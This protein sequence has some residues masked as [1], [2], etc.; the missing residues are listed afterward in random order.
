ME[1]LRGQPEGKNLGG[2]SARHRVE[3]GRASGSASPAPLRFWVDCWEPFRE[4]HA[5][6]WCRFGGRGPTYLLPLD[7]LAACSRFPAG[8]ARRRLAS[9]SL[10][11]P[12]DAEAER[13]FALACTAFAPTSAGAWDGRPINFPLLSPQESLLA[14][15]QREWESLGWAPGP[16]GRCLT[17]IEDV[18]GQADADRH[19]RLGYAGRLTFDTQ[20]RR[21]KSEIKSRWLKLDVRP[22]FPLDA[23]AVDHLSPPVPS[24]EPTLGDVPAGDA[25]GFRDEVGRFLRKW[26]LARLVT[27]DLPEPQ[28]PLGAL[29]L[30][31]AAAMLGPE[32]SVWTFPTY[33]DISS[34]QDVRGSIR[35]EQ[36]RAA[37]EA[38]VVGMQH[39]VTDTSARAGSA[40]GYE[41]A[42][43]LWL[44]ERSVRVRYGKDRGQVARLVSAFAEL[45]GCSEERIRQLRKSYR[46][47]LDD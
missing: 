36:G 20:F 9:R 45:L 8:G 31:L 43:R 33:Y 17:M 24:V 10:L 28:G 27:W 11:G 42:F 39:P 29:P 15:A 7:F 14:Q 18:E 13:Q 4:R 12:E 44:I 26:Q 6:W 23:F 3:G 22:T 21:E 1:D 38:G 40:S 34:G 2:R 46:E 25:D 32:T 19:Q 5:D 47:F 35:E 30:G 41:N 37:R 16:C